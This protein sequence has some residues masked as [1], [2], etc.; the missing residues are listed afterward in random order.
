MDEGQLGNT[1]DLL[2]P[3]YEPVPRFEA[4]RG[5]PAEGSRD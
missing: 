3:E 1:K 4:R 5:P 2:A